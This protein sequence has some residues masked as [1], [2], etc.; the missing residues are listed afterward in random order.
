MLAAFSRGEADILVGT[1]MIVKGHDFSR[2]TL[3]GI[4][5]AD[6]SLHA[7][8]FRAGEKTFQL[9]TQA[10]GRAG[11]GIRP[12]KVLIQTYQP[13]HYA[14]VT[15]GMQDYEEFYEQEMTY[16]R[17]L[18]YPPTCEMLVIFCTSKEKEDGIK[19]LDLI[20]DYLKKSYGSQSF[21]LIGPAEGAFPKINDVYRRVLYIK[22]N[23][24][25]LLMAIREKIEKYTET[26]E[27]FSRVHLYYDRN[28]MGIY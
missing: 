10:A 26:E 17:L 1:Q 6:L 27:I 23:D 22:E 25:N 16:R 14:I 2:V 5:A 7:G 11:R 13:D 12:G 18:K 20:A 9:L 15:A 19:A 28:P 3:M 8:D 21:T 4:L 24:S